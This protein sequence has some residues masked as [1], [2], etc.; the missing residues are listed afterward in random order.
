MRVAFRG[1]APRIRY[2]WTAFLSTLLVIS[3]F[4]TSAATVLLFSF[5]SVP[6][7][8]GNGLSE[9]DERTEF[10]ALPAS[11]DLS[12]A[13]ASSDLKP[14]EEVIATS[15]QSFFSKREVLSNS[16]GAELLFW[17]ND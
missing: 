4:L 1:Q 12:G 14:L 16:Y 11:R 2:A 6:A 9:L 13:D 17:A 8:V 5:G 7:I 10:P 3:G 15:E